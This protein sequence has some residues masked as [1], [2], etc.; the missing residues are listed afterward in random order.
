MVGGGATLLLLLL[1]VLHTSAETRQ[2]RELT[3]HLLT[4]VPF[5]LLTR[6]M[7]SRAV[8]GSTVC[9]RPPHWS[10]PVVTWRQQQAHKNCASMAGR[11]FVLYLKRVVAIGFVEIDRMGNGCWISLSSPLTPKN[12]LTFLFPELIT[13]TAVLVL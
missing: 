9:R 3:L 2:L 10:Q 8:I 6:A 13:K 1:L 12:C 11:N 5:S 7:Q 4:P